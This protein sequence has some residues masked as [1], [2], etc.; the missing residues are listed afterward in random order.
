MFFFKPTS[1]HYKGYIFDAYVCRTMASY[2]RSISNGNYPTPNLLFLFSIYPN[3]QQRAGYLTVFT[4]VHQ[5]LQDEREKRPAIKGQSSFFCSAS[6]QQTAQPRTSAMNPNPPAASSSRCLHVGCPKR[7]TYGV[8]LSRKRE[9]CAEHALP[10]MVNID[11]T[12]C[13]A[14][15]PPQLFF[16]CFLSRR[17]L[18]PPCVQL[19]KYI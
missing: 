17:C 14:L 8:D 19:V 15:P 4:A 6:R 3:E 9:S 1:L 18:T 7:P 13:C 11:L 2:L 16:I 10:G 12:R 5:A